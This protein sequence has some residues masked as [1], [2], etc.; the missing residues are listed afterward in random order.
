MLKLFWGEGKTR[1]LFFIFG[2]TLGAKPTYKDQRGSKPGPP[3]ASSD[4]AHGLGPS[5]SR[6]RLGEP[7]VNPTTC[8]F[9]LFVSRYQRAPQPATLQSLRSPGSSLSSRL[10]QLPTFPARPS[11]RPRAILDSSFSFA[12]LPSSPCPLLRHLVNHRVLSVSP[13]T[14]S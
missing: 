5:W 4:S 6:E 12:L 8:V 10:A 7:L 3:P 11:P 1:W 14:T 9:C 13:L 2:N